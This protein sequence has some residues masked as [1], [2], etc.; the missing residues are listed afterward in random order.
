M[1]DFQDFFSPMQ[2]V[3]GIENTTSRM[4]LVNKTL[5]GVFLLFFGGRGLLGLKIKQKI[6]RRM[7]LI[8]FQELIFFPPMY[9]Q[10]VHEIESLEAE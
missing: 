6:F 5:G 7:V 3:R 2:C 10:L 9:M 4:T 8:D 1:I